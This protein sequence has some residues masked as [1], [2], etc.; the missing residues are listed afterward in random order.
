MDQITENLTDKSLDMAG[1][2][3][4]RLI[5]PS[6]PRGFIYGPRSPKSQQTST[7]AK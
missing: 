5:L 4:E 6:S 2:A 7:N 3:A 1:I